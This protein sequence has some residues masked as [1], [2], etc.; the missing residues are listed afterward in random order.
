MDPLLKKGKGLRFTPTEISYSA[1][2]KPLPLPITSSTNSPASPSSTKKKAKGGHRL[3]NEAKRVEKGILR[4]KIQMIMRKEKNTEK[5]ES[6]WESKT[7]CVESVTVAGESIVPTLKITPNQYMGQHVGTAVAAMHDK[8]HK[9]WLHSATLGEKELYRNKSRNQ[10]VIFRSINES[11]RLNRFVGKHFP[12]IWS[13]PFVYFP[14][15]VPFFV[16]FL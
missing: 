16:L 1:P 8:L 4:K 15:S 2:L 10:K 13:N 12:I 3:G 11:N 9:N 6:K 7:A 14:H 5:L